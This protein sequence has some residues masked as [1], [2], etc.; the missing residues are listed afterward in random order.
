MGIGL[1]SRANRWSSPEMMTFA[2]PAKA[3][4]INLSSEGSALTKGLPAFTVITSNQDKISWL[5]MKSISDSE[6]L[7]LG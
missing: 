5:R 6:R 3:H 1:E 4:Q 7:N 2:F